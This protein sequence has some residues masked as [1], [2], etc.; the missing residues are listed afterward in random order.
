MRVTATIILL[1]ASLPCGAAAA[2]VLNCQTTAVAAAVR[3]EGVAERL[4]D[5]LLHCS[6]GTP[7]AQVR[8]SLQVFLPV[9][10]T[11]RVSSTGTVDATLT[12]DL[13]AGQVSVG[14]VAR[15]TG[16]NSVVFSDFSFTLPAS[17]QAV[18]RVSNLRGDVSQTP[19]E[20]PIAATLSLTGPTGIF[21]DR[22][23]LAVGVPQ[24][25]LLAGGATRVWCGPGSLPETRSFLEMAAA[26]RFS[27][28][29][30]TEGFPTAFLSRQAGED[31][32]VRVLLRYTGL[33]AGI[34]VAVPDSIA[35]SNALQPTSAGDLGRPA[36]AGRY[37]SSSLLLVR[38][39]DTDAF[40]GGGALVP[41]PPVT[42][43][44][45]ELDTVSS[46]EVRNGAAMAVYEVVQANPNALEHAQIPTF[47]GWIPGAQINAAF[48]QLEVYLAPQAVAGGAAWVPRFVPVMPP[49]DCSLLQDCM[50]GYFPRLVVDAPSLSFS[51]E[52]GAGHQIEFIRVL[53]QGGGAMDWTVSVTYRSGSNWL[54][55]FPLE[56]RNNATVRVDALP[57]QMTPGLYTAEIVIDAGA[58]AGRRTLSVSFL[59]RPPAPVTP[60]IEG[61]VNAAS[62]AGGPV[63]PGSLVFV[64]GRRI[65]EPTLQL[66]VNGQAAQ[67]LGLFGGR[68]LMLVP[69]NLAGQ[70]SAILQAT[71]EGLFSAPFTLRLTPVAPTVFPGGILNADNSA[72]TATQPALVGDPVQVFATGLPPPTVGRISARI[73]D[74]DIDALDYAGPAPGW[75]GIQQV[76]ARI[77]ADLPAMTTELLVC[78]TV[79]GQARVCSPPAPLTLRR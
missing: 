78:A 32:G 29:R 53:N 9:Q 69:E 8:G 73:H 62:G 2:S 26:G 51:A 72:N 55:V 41:L 30:V 59:V 1:V 45:I 58:Q 5:I 70:S 61:V 66:L 24:R 34:Q 4:G 68:A 19:E 63:A 7:G 47:L 79:P 52:A 56:G 13:G 11:N 42:G 17:G 35:G 22:N 37:L 75:T 46:L 23:Q 36:S 57:A 60:A 21:L 50:A 15:P 65:A 12:A 39:R 48:A 49:L 6:Q 76:N 27:T 40:G 38:V 20:R 64:S 3:A 54:R 28:L 43:G 16:A 71:V 18:L 74:R 33:P 31:Q 14:A 44:V 67:L 25:A 77:P 10:L